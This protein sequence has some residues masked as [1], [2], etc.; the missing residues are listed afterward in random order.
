MQTEIMMY[1]CQICRGN[2]SKHR[3]KKKEKIHCP[4]RL[5][6]KRNTFNKS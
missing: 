3:D 1:N 5:K 2:N 4:I 6:K